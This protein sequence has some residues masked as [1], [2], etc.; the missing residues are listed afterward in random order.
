MSHSRNQWTFSRES[1]SRCVVRDASGTVYCEG[2][3]DL[4]AHR[5]QDFMRW[6]APPEYAGGPENTPFGLK[7]EGRIEGEGVYDTPA[8]R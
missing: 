6:T 2:H 5:C 8:V 1:P 4:A 3:G 7:P